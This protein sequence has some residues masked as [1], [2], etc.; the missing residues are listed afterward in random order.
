MIDG[1]DPVYY[2]VALTTLDEGVLERELTPLRQIRDNFPKYL[3][4]L[5]QVFPDISYEG[6]IKK[7]VLRWMLDGNT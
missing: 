7:N 4:T 5:D 3:L 1:G 6:I 2:Q